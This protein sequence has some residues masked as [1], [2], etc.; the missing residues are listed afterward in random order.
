MQD[1]ILYWSLTGASGG[2]PPTRKRLEYAVIAYHGNRTLPITMN[3]CCGVYDDDK[4]TAV[5]RAEIQWHADN[6]AEVTL[7]A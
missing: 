2:V 5:N 1:K 3:I 6:G 7:P 4:Y